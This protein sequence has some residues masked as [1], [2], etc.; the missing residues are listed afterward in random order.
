M[1]INYRMI[2]SNELWNPPAV[3]GFDEKSRMLG[4]EWMGTPQLPCLTEFF[5]MDLLRS[6]CWSELQNYTRETMTSVR[7]W[8]VQGSHGAVSDTTRAP[9]TQP[10]NHSILRCGQHCL[11]K[12][13]TS[14]W[15]TNPCPVLRTSG[16]PHPGPPAFLS[17][18]GWQGCHGTKRSPSHQE[19]KGG[20]RRRNHVRPTC[21]T[22][23]VSPLVG[24]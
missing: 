8:Q 12:G 19:A 4:K 5:Q 13:L 16:D 11:W 23:C 20:K 9:S 3:D 2:T 7:K 24:L 21:T 17:P 15:V 14:Q 22:T 6:Q 18:P 1:P 10:Q